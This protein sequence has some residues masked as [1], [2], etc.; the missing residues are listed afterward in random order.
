MWDREAVKKFKTSTPKA[1]S[2]AATPANAAANAVKILVRHTGLMIPRARTFYTARYGARQI[3][4]FGHKFRSVLQ[5]ALTKTNSRKV[6][7]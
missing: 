2:H 7:K 5:C 1:I 3:C 4:V 6:G